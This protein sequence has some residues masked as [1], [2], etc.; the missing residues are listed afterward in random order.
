MSFKP[1]PD[2]EKELADL[3][4]AGNQVAAILAWREA[5]GE[6]LTRSKE[7]VEAIEN[8]LRTHSPEKFTEYR[9]NLNTLFRNFDIEGTQLSVAGQSFDLHAFLLQGYTHDTATCTFDLTFRGDTY[10]HSP[11][12]ETRARTDLTFTFHA[13][14]FLRIQDEAQGPPMIRFQSMRVVS[15]LTPKPDMVLRVEQEMRERNAV[16]P[17][18]DAPYDEGASPEI[19]WREY[20]YITLVWGV[21][22]LI[23]AERI[24][25]S[26]H[27]AAA[28]EGYPS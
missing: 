8:E 25:A 13:V 4:M 14:R 26:F 3:I 9:R 16:G 2:L 22:I 12:A 5:S 17:E 28:V 21:E 24:E 20:V 19:D 18:A 23:S 11:Q 15:G 7:V 6:S 27:Q 10:Y 1:G